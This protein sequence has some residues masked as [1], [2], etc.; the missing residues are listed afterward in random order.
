M[1]YWKYFLTNFADTKIETFFYI[2][3]SNTDA[4]TFFRD[5]I[6]FDTDTEPFPLAKFSDTDT[7]TL[8]NIWKGLENLT[9][10]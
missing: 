3:V 4:E 5:Q 6:C 10:H 9:S 2:K 1:C 8:K 7:D